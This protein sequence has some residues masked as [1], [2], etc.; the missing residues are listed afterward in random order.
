MVEIRVE[1]TGSS[2]TTNEDGVAL[3]SLSAGE[4]ILRVS[5]PGHAPLRRP[6]TI[7][8][9][10]ERDLLISLSEARASISDDRILIEDKV[11][12]ETGSASLLPRSHS[13]LDEVALLI[14][15]HPE[16][17]L[18][19]VQGHTDSVGREEDNTALSSARADAVVAYLTRAGIAAQRLY[20]VGKGE[21]VPLVSE[22]SDDARAQN[23]R[24]EF[25]VRDAQSQ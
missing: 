3:L 7:E 5:A 16:L 2:I 8:A 1:N 4:H 17:A 20:A 10:A 23:R 19:E 12:F 24:V 14:L 18:I 6:L 11:Y 15:D 9:G 22:D 25:H 13:L 21:T